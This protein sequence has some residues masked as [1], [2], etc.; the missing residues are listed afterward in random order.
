MSLSKLRTIAT[1]ETETPPPNPTDLVGTS[2]VDRSEQW[3][4]DNTGLPPIEKFEGWKNET[5]DWIYTFNNKEYKWET[6]KRLHPGGPN[7]AISSKMEDLTEQIGTKASN[8]DVEFSIRDWA[9]ELPKELLEQ[10][11]PTYE[12]SLSINRLK[13]FERSRLAAYTAATRNVPVIE[14]MIRDGGGLNPLKSTHQEL[15]ELIRATGYETIDHMG[16]NEEGHLTLP[17]GDN[18]LQLD[19]MTDP[20]IDPEIAVINNLDVVS[21]YE[22]MVKRLKNEARLKARQEDRKTLFLAFDKV[23]TPTIPKWAKANII[24]DYASE[25]SDG[26]E[27]TLKAVSDTITE[28]ITNFSMTPEEVTSEF[29]GMVKEIS[30]KIEGRLA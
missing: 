28:N 4:N 7:L 29:V 23:H 21:I 30:S 20:E 9:H 6:E 27:L 24:I 19:T 17:V 8:E 1:G 11:I 18:P 10:I 15:T 25:K 12:K 16:I 2:F 22:P 3:L 14:Q 13:A 5:K 26:P